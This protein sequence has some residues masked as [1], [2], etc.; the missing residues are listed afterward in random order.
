MS[1]LSVFLV[2][3]PST[4]PQDTMPCT[5]TPMNIP[6]LAASL[7][8][9]LASWICHR[10]LV[11]TQSLPQ[12][13]FWNCRGKCPSTLNGD[14][15]PLRHCPLTSKPSEERGGEGGRKLGWHASYLVARVVGM[16]LISW[17]HVVAFEAESQ[18]LGERAMPQ[19]LGAY[20]PPV[21]MYNA[22]HVK[23]VS[24]QQWV[25]RNLQWFHCYVFLAVSLS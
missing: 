22:C 9:D 10:P 20:L 14:V 16:S 13:H 15:W 17:W 2:R 24:H 18:S 5:E 12:A 25:V 23:T 11:Q 21:Y 1:H 4:L 6:L 19:C 3:L 8:D 7:S